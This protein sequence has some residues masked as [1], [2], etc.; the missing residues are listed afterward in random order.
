M[1]RLHD[2]LTEHV[3]EGSCHEEI[4]SFREHGQLVPALG[5]PLSDDPKYE[6]E[7]VY[8][9][10]R[11]F[12]AQYLKRPLLVE[13][14]DMTDKD[15]LIAMDMENRQR[16]DI[17]PYER[18]L[19]YA[20]W[21][22]VGYFESQDDLAAQLSISPSRVSRLLKLARLPSVIIDAFECAADICEGW[23]VD[24]AAAI[25]DP[26]RRSSA[27]QAARAIAAVSPRPP[28]REVYRHLLASSVR[29]R[30]PRP[31][32]RDQVVKDDQG[33]SLFRVRQ[34]PRSIAV[35]LPQTS[36]SSRTLAAI[37]EAVAQILDPATDEEIA[38]A[39]EAV[40]HCRA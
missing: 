19:S 32:L 27:I 3:N 13:L 16:K 40:T 18:G 4:Q 36:L 7:L 10:R 29:G 35:V 12:V 8:G 15:A 39:Q 30:K 38:S 22:R 11:L 2:R 31:M 14:R 9:A 21:L 28:A 33:N 37:Q 25:K 24:L 5:R 26:R 6:V 23:G 34:R 17:S 1:W 20:R